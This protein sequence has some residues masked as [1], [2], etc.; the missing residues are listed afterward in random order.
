MYLFNVFFFTLSENWKAIDFVLDFQ[1]KLNLP[2]DLQSLCE[3]SNEA[4]IFKMLQTI[5]RVC[6]DTIKM[7]KQLQRICFTNQA[8]IIR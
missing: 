6:L 1:F 4:G 2:F 3:G 5:D 7:G 8:A